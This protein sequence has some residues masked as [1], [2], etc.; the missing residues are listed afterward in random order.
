[1][2]VA[3]EKR[4]KNIAEYVLYMWQV[5][6]TLRALKFDMNLIEERLITQFKQSETVTNEIRDWYT[7]LIL[8]MHEEG[9]KETG[10]LKL[11]QG[12]TDELY[13][14]HKRLLYEQKDKNYIDLY[15]VTKPNID[16]FFDK[17]KMPSANEIETCFY[18]LYALLLLRVKKK[19]VSEET[20][21]AMQTF[22][23]ML[24]TL[25]AHFHNIESGKSEF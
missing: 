1:M 3:R 16:A 22:S 23:N 14:L 12:I 4:K 19:K 15:K 7:N 18:G 2:I 11:V 17:L 13:Q 25:S 10:H 5:E 20:T 24:A 6:D 21:R 9:I 8:A